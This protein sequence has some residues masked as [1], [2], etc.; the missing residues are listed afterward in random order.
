MPMRV[1]VAQASGSELASWR[2]LVLLLS[3]FGVVVVALLA[4]NRRERFL[5]RIPVGLERVTKV[6]GWA[7]AAVGTALFGLLVA[8]EGFYSDVAWHV[9][10]GRDE[11]L[12][13]AP[14]TSIFV[15]LWLIFLS[16]GVA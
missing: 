13:T 1:M 4:T 10:L 11:V 9:A 5:R 15:G 16:A 12:F 3:L 2:P 6:P 14:H 8:G 7:A